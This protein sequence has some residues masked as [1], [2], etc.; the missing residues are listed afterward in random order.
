M[1]P[2]HA[3]FSVDINSSSVLDVQSCEGERT[4]SNFC[5]IRNVCM[6]VY[7]KYETYFKT[8]QPLEISS[9]MAITVGLCGH[10]GNSPSHV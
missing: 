6:I 5:E 9:V 8:R 2:G 7:E 3:V 10:L 4:Q 1:S